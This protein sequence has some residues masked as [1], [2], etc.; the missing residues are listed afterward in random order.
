MLVYYFEPAGERR[1]K[2]SIA[3]KKET[4]TKNIA[5]T[6]MMGSGKSSVS[7]ELSKLLPDF[8]LIDIDN[9]IEKSTN[10]KISEIF[11]KFGEPHFRMLET[12]KIQ[13]SFHVLFCL[14]FLIKYFSDL[15]L[16]QSPLFFYDDIF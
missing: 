5:L 4:M 10:K 8:T 9:E 2:Y 14:C 11:L 16:M 3:Q 15:L 12:D 13:K 7:Q 1:Q 6:G